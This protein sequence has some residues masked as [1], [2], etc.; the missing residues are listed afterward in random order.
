MTSDGARACPGPIAGMPPKKKRR[1]E[2]PE[3]SH[4]DSD[5]SPDDGPLPDTQFSNL[6]TH[7]LKSWAWGVMPAAEVQRI[8]LSAYRDGLR[9]PEVAKLAALG[10]WGNYPGN[11]HQ[12]L[13]TMLSNSQNMLPVPMTFEVACVD[14]KTAQAAK[15]DCSALLPHEWF[16]AL[17]HRYRAEF[18][19]IFGVGRLAEFW[20]SASR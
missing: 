12:Q 16:S 19:A 17:Y 10:S 8:A 20:N 6:G 15:A 2:A 7:L 14:P 5:G 1:L 4:G 13:T 9:H 3:P 18:N 11:V